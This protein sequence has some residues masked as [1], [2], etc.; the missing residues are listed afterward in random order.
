MPIACLSF[1]ADTRPANDAAELIA[2]YG[3]GARDEARAR[4]DRSRTLGNHIHFCRWRQV[5]RLVALLAT[6]AV[7]GTL[8]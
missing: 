1:L 8:H 4:A 5:A 3:E 2:R 7:I 6:D